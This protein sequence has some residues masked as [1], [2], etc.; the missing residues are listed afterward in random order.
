MKKIITPI[1]NGVLLLPLTAISVAC[2]FAARRY[3]ILSEWEGL[4]DPPILILGGSLIIVFGIPFFWFSN[5]LTLRFEKLKNAK[6][7][8]HFRQSLFFYLTIILSLLTWI[9]RGYS[10]TEDDGYLLLWSGYSIVAIVINYLFIRRE[11]NAT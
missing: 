11:I 2:E 4:I 6:T 3:G 1:I 10:G 9:F 5:R 7:F 8:D